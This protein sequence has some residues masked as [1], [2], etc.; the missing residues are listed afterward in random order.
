[1]EEERK[2]N[3]FTIIFCSTSEGRGTTFMH[4]TKKSSVFVL[5]LIIFISKKI[6]FVNSDLKKKI[7]KKKLFR[8]KAV[9]GTHGA[10]LHV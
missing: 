3:L 5:L 10:T 9:H 6:N 8:C 2:C 1:M 7:I 4:E